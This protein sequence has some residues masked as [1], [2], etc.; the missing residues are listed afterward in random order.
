[1]MHNVPIICSNAGSLPEVAGD[2][3]L[4]FKSGNSSDLSNSINKMLK[5]DNSQIETLKA[6][7]KKQLQKFT[8]EK[9]AQQMLEALQS[10]CEKKSTIE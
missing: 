1:M 2:T 4:V 3:A 8:W 9:C 5:L 7:G 6:R 10:V